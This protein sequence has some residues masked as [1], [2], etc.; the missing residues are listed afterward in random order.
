MMKVSQEPG[1][2]SMHSILAKHKS[3][4]SNKSKVIKDIKSP[5]QSKF[6]MASFTDMVTKQVKTK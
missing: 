6:K 1:P 2:S 5:H 4:P 3:A